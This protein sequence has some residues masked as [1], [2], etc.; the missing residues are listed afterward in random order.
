MTP[1]AVICGNDVLAVGAIKRAKSMGLAIPDD[2]SITGFDDIDIASFVT[3]ALTTV[4]VPHR[5]M[6]SAA[7][8]LLLQLIAGERARRRVEIGVELRMRGSLG[9]VPET[10][11]G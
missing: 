3:P 1:S 5:R 9:P 8:Q 7:A 6:G 11:A 10:A 2:V 4:H